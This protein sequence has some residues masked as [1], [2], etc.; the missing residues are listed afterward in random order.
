MTVIIHF[1]PTGVMEFFKRIYKWSTNSGVGWQIKLALSLMIYTTTS[2]IGF[3]KEYRCNICAYEP[4]VNVYVY[5]NKAGT[6]GKYRKHCNALLSIFF[7]QFVVIFQRARAHT[8][9]W[10]RDKFSV[11]NEWEI[12]QIVGTNSVEANCANI[13]RTLRGAVALRSHWL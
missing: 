13:V 8:K 6:V 5:E 4:D 7:L 2:T 10:N 3:Y 9:T 11:F 1:M 12:S